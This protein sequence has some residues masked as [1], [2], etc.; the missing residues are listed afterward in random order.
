MLPKPHEFATLLAQ[1]AGLQFAFLNETTLAP[2]LLEW[3]D[4]DLI[5][6]MQDLKKD[7]PNLRT[8]IAIGGW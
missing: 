7:N 1:S 5:S 6:Q 8:L 4:E 2:K 3:N